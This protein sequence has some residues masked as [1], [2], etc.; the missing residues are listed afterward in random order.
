MWARDKKDAPPDRLELSTSRWPVSKNRNLTVERASQLR[1]GGIEEVVLLVAGLVGPDCGVA[2]T[3][4]IYR[5]GC[6]SVLCF[7]CQPARVLQ[8]DVHDGQIPALTYYSLLGITHARC[9]YME[10]MRKVVD[11]RLDLHCVQRSKL[12]DTL[13]NYSLHLREV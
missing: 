5:L 9:E 1:H 4:R 3:L 12:F 11:R 6:P 7:D 8:S 10:M 2:K 13:L